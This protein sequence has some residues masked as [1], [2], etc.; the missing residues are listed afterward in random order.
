[1]ANIVYSLLYFLRTMQYS[2]NFAVVKRDDMSHF[3]WRH[4]KKNKKKKNKIKDN[5]KT[6]RLFIEKVH[7]G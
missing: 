5:N 3:F 4:S 2:Y 7:I 1:M 6:Q